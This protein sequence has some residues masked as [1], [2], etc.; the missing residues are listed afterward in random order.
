VARLLG[1]GQCHQ[2][3]SLL[4]VPPGRGILPIGASRMLLERIPAMTTTFAVT[5]GRMG[6][7]AGRIGAM[8][9]RIGVSAGRIGATVS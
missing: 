5:A 9:R 8:A 6:V 7:M 2:P 1:V 3:D 4:R